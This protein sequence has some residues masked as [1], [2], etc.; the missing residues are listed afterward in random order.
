MVVPDP[1]IDKVRPACR[2]GRQLAEDEERIP[3]LI[4]RVRAIEQYGPNLSAGT[5][6]K[7]A[8]GL[9]MRPVQRS[10]VWSIG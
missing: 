9:P 8:I 4:V 3:V 1:P 10:P 2:I 7:T 6:A 5:D